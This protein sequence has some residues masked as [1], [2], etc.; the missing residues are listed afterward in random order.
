MPKR[1]HN[2]GVTDAID[3]KRVPENGSCTCRLAAVEGADRH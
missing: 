1:S 2:V 3:C